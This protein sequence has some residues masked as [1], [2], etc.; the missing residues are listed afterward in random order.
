MIL[1]IEL[2]KYADKDTSVL[3]LKKK[4]NKWKIF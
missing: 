4:T 3:S 2:L 1:K